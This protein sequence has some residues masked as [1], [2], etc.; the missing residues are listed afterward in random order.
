M[1][2][3]ITLF[4]G[5]LLAGALLPLGALA[6]AV[7]CSAAD[8]E[9]G[10]TVGTCKGG[11]STSMAA[12]QSGRARPIELITAMSST[13][14][15]G[16]CTILATPTSGPGRDELRFRRALDNVNDAFSFVL[17]EGALNRFWA[18]VLANSPGCPGA[19]PEQVAFAFLREIVPPGPGPWIAPGF[20]LTGKHAFLETR[21]PATVPQAHP[22]PIGTLE[23]T[24][25]A[26][27][28]EVDWGD[29]TGADQG[30][31][32]APGRPW[33]NGEARHTYTDIDRYDVVVTQS[34]DAHWRLAGQSGVLRGLTSVDR[35]EDLE[36]RQLQ[37]VRNS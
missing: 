4:L 2:R 17:P 14:E 31:F 35:L 29:G 11:G 12:G 6:Q 30:P 34:W 28:F 36:V 27:S 8:T 13:Q 3:L 23:V 24:L 10:V 18:R 32:A 15:T 37:A 5:V 9:L 1:R 25:T 33:P 16:A 26:T 7:D 21:A 22:T 19:T 20:A